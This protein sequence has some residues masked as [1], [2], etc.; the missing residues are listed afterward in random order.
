MVK[1][2]PKS[3]KVIVV[4]LSFFSSVYLAFVLTSLREL[5]ILCWTTHVINSWLL[6]IHVL[7]KKKRN[8]KKELKF[9]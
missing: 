5:C 4:L 2:V 7:G 8:K 9:I 3:V 1:S 6:G